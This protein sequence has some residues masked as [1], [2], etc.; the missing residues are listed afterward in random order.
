MRIPNCFQWFSLLR[1]H[2]IR[3]LFRITDNN[4]IFCTGKRKHTGCNIHL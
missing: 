1:F 3:K 4:R 2:N